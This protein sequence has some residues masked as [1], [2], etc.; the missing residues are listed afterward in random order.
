MISSFDLHDI[1]LS[2]PSGQHARSWSTYHT[3]ETHLAGQGLDQAEWTEARWKEFGIPDTHISSHD[4]EVPLPRGNQRVALL[5][6]DKVEYVAPMVDGPASEDKGFVSALFGFSANAN[7]TADYVYCNF[8]SE[9]DFQEMEQHNVNVTGKI[10]IAKLANASPYLRERGLE[11]FR[12][13]QVFNAEKAGLIGLILY[14]DPM[15]DGP[16]LEW[17]GYKPY[18]YGVARPP[19]AIE[20]GGLGNA[21]EKR[22]DLLILARSC[23]ILLLT[24]TTQRISTVDY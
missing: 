15:N 3:S 22:L 2:V 20:R 14:T 9:E 10:G 18:P 19:T 17:N 7:I 21:G 6:G 8:A 4:T 11:S 13:A 5:D 16:L 1:L 23:R 12:A 24:S